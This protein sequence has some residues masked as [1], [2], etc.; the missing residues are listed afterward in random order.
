MIRIVVDGHSLSIDH[1]ELIGYKKASVEISMEALKRLEDTRRFIED[2]VR[3][4]EVFYGITTGFGILASKIVEPDLA[5]QL[6]LNLLRSHS[7]G[8]GDYAPEPLIRMTM[9]I[10]MNTL[11]KGA[12]GVRPEILYLFREF[13]NKHVYPLVPIKGSVGASGD[14]APLSHLALA[15]VGDPVAEVIYKGKKYSGEKL[16]E[17]LLEE[18]YADLPDNVKKNLGILEHNSRAN[19]PL[20]RLSYKEGLALNNGTAFSAA[21]LA[22]GIIKLRKILKLATTS[23]AL[24]LEGLAGFKDPFTPEILES[25]YSRNFSKSVLELIK[26]SKLVRSNSDTANIASIARIEISR[27]HVEMTLRKDILRGYGIYPFE[28]LKNLSRLSSEGIDYYED[29]NSVYLTFRGANVDELNDKL[30]SVA[31]KDLGLIQDPYSIRCSP[32]IYGSFLEA[33][34]FA[35]NI[36]EREINTACDNPLI[37]SIDEKYSVISCGNF[38]GQAIG[39]ASDVLAIA[40]ATLSNII[41][42]RVQL[43]LDSRFNRGLT[44]CL[45][46]PRSIP[47]VNSGLMMVQY[48]AAALAAENRALA[49]SFSVHSIPTSANQEDIVSMCTNAALRLQDMIENLINA[50]SIEVVVALQAIFLRAEI[51]KNKIENLLGSG[52]REAVK[53]FTEAVQ[54]SGISLPLKEDIY[55]KSYLDAVR[56]TILRKLEEL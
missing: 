28:L 1:L 3:R 32:Q 44:D 16:K 19:E 54:E 33:L 13:L 50:I 17:L 38:H 41:E 23:L 26:G 20:I 40:I 48:T 21:L 9:A 27:D 37:V 18:V 52:T 36:L 45:I 22:D 25:E 43:L 56:D 47:G 51:L 29:E 4:G 49:N 15:L 10:R 42:R 8:V 39:L 24:S 31:W 14:L 30:K 55:L 46:H 5:E 53:F 11:A 7:V 2:S 12:S 6:Q 35:K 34:D